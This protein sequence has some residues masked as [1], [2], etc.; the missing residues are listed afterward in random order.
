MVSFCVRK[1]STLDCSRWEGGGQLLLV[2]L[3]R[4]VL[5]LQVADLGLQPRLAGQRLAGE[6]FAPAA[7]R[8]PGLAVQLGLL[9][10]GASSSGARPRFR[11][12]ATSA[13]P[14][15][16]CVSISSWRW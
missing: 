15:R 1:A 14:R 13:T 9:A 12:V 8:L 6:L 4:L 10:A 5:R 2:R 3:Q 7:Q 16:T 11:D